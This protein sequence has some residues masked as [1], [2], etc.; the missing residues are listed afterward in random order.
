MKRFFSVM[1]LCAFS[2][3]SFAQS[4]PVTAAVRDTLQRRQ[5]NLVEAAQQM[6]PDKYAFKPTPAQ[7][8]FA[9]LIGHI[10][11]SNGFLCSKIS[12]SAAP[13]QQVSDADPKEKLVDALKTSFDFCS[14]AL[15][16][17]SDAR[18]GDEVSL[19]GGRKSTKAAAVIALTSDWADHYSAA[20][21]YLRLN[22]LLPPTAKTKE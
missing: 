4:N 11:Q 1:L 3:L 5:K 22:G 15:N 18:L 14:T 21:M 8:S 20:A 2:L 7:M 10:A 6:P 16:Q 19:F 17:F 9:H 12:G 13:Q